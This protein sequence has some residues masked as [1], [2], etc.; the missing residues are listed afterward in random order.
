[1]IDP[2]KESRFDI[3][4]F[5]DKSDGFFSSLL[6]YDP[7]TTMSD[8]EEMKTIDEIIDTKSQSSQVPQQP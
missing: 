4:A 2:S 8:L 5:L 7:S 6:S 1:M 3:N